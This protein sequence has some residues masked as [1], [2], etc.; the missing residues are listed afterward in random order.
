MLVPE[1]LQPGDNLIY[2]A[3]SLFGWII[4]IKCWH[5][6][7]S[8][9]EMYAG[10]GRTFAARASGV[11]CYEFELEN[12][13]Y[14]LRP[15]YHFDF[16]KAEQWFYKSALNQKYDWLGVFTVFTTIRNHGDRNRQWCSELVTR[17]DR[18]AGLDPFSPFTDADTVAPFQLLT[19]PRLKLVWADEKHSKANWIIRN[20]QD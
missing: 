17:L 5:P 20:F 9:C 18:A 11:R 2:R 8:H 10:N 3:S 16:F 7:A 4:G 13:S 6:S 12:L 14:V 15:K 1:E 19:S